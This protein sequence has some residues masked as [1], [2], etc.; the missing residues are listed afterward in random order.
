MEKEKPKVNLLAL[1]LIQWLDQNGLRE[2]YEVET[3]QDQTRILSMVREEN[4]RDGNIR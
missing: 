4:R 1:A 3:V 2:E